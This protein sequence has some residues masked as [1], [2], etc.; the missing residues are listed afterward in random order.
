[1]I[2][3]FEE[4]INHIYY[5]TIDYINKNI[6]LLESSLEKIENEIN[7]KSIKEFLYFTESKKFKTYLNDKNN[8]DK[9][10]NIISYVELGFFD[11]FTIQE[12]DRSIMN[13]RNNNNKVIKK[14]I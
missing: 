2:G 1:M 12:K 11:I 7:K 13:I 4:W 8:L 3:T 5:N 14:I 6:F 10:K 9:L